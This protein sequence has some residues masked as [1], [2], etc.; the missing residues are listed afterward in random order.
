MHVRTGRTDTGNRQWCRDLIRAFGR[1]LDNER[2]CVAHRVPGED[3]RCRWLGGSDVGGKRL[4]LG[5]TRAANHSLPLPSA[6]PDDDDRAGF[7]DDVGAGYD[8]DGDHRHDDN[9]E[10]AATKCSIDHSSIYNDLVDPCGPRYHGHL[11]VR[12]VGRSTKGGDVAEHGYRLT[13]PGVHRTAADHRRWGCLGGL[14]RCSSES[15]GGRPGLNS[16]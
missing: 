15:I 4:L 10:F 2:S 14:F 1:L 3:S 6:R 12:R 9:D 13:N 8:D 7:D 11:D 5:W 16:P